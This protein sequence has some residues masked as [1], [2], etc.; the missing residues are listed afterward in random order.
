MGVMV[1]GVKEAG[2]ENEHGGRKKRKRGRVNLRPPKKISRA[3]VEPKSNSIRE[4]ALLL[5]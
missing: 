1:C 2:C 5:T 3:K 4:A